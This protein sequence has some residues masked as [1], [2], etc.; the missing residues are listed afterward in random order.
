MDVWEATSVTRRQTVVREMSIVR[1]FWKCLL[2]SLITS[3]SPPTPHPGYLDAA[4]ARTQSAKD[5]RRLRDIMQKS[6]RIQSTDDRDRLWENLRVKP[7]MKKPARRHWTDRL[8]TICGCVAVSLHTDAVTFRRCSMKP[9]P[10]GSLT[11]P[12]IAAILDERELPVTHEM[13][14]SVGPE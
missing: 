2:S 9:K 4:D 5:Q 14:S 1:C 6:M 10:R 7:P 3:G 11:A 8:D 12:E 13:T